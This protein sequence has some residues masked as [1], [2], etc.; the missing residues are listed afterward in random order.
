MKRYGMVIGL[1]PEAEENFVVRGHATYNVRPVQRTCQLV[2]GL[3]CLSPTVH[4]HEP[5]GPSSLDS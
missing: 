4:P 2:F 5:F 1:K 3:R